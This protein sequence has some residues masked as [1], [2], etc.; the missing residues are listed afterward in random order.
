[1]M[2]SDHRPSPVTLLSASAA[3][4][5]LMIASPAWAQ[6]DPAAAVTPVSPADLAAEDT[7]ETIIVTA[8]KREQILLDVP[9]SVSVVAEGTLERQQAVSIVDY[10]ELVPGLSLTQD[11][12]G[13]T[14]IVLRGVNTGSVSSTVGVYMDETP[15]GS[16][17]S[18]ANGGVLA[19]DFDTFDVARIEVLR[20]PQGTLYG[21]NALGGV[22][23]FVTNEPNTNRLEA[24]AQATLESVDDGGLGGSAAGVINVPIGDRAAIRATGFY[25]HLEGFIDAVGRPN[26]DINDADSYGGRVS[27]LVEPTDDISVRLTAHAQNIRVD[28]SSSFDADPVTFDPLD[29]DPTTG[30]PVDGLT[31][32]Q[33]RPDNQDVDYRLYSG[34]VD[35]DLGFA[36][37]TS[38]TAYGVIDQT[39]QLD[40]TIGLGPTI[41]FLYGTFGGTTEDLGVFL[42]GDVKTKKFTQEVRLSSPDSDTFEW[43][44]GGYYTH[45]KA[46]IFQRFEP[47]ELASLNE[48]PRGLL[49]FDEFIVLTLD[50]KYKEFSGFGNITWHVSPQFEVSAGGR[51]SHNKQSAVQ[52]QEGA[53]LL[54]VGQD[55]PQLIT[56]ES[57]EN[58][59]TWSFSPLYK[60]TEDTSVYARAAKGYRPGGPNAVPPGAGP[61]FPF[62]FDADTLVS[63]EAGIKTQSS[64]RRF[65]LDAAVYYIDWKDVLIFASF[66]SDIGPV[67]ANDNG[68]K[69]TSYGAE[70]AATF[71]P[72]TGLT[73]MANVAYNKAELKDDTPPVTGGLDGDELPFSPRWSGTLSADYEWP[74]FGDSIA[75]V[76][77]DFRFVSEQAAGFDQGY[78]EEFGRRL[79]LPSYEV[80]DLRAGVDLGNFSLTAFVR[81][82]LNSGG[83]TNLG[84]FGTRPVLDPTEPGITA[85]SASPIR[86]RTFGVTLGAEF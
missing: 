25:R 38:A 35:W 68:G 83:L 30:D 46:G 28:D 84:G 21:A 22:L 57:S 70:A 40:Q 79:E 65:T 55:S 33:F 54:L 78:R 13:E 61:E 51:Y 14:R 44:I 15:F 77:G 4:L 27:F 11:N 66:D 80:V 86:P 36:T 9:Q 18:L 7:E 1:M 49:G 52:F 3:T 53:F 67:G 43:L 39:Q 17:S 2:G 62:Q 24:R 72:T 47:F 82:L 5:A 32:T 69:A 31:R 6:E 85:L 29:F 75:F 48:I 59:F 45:E 42:R 34:I 73:L 58:V 50:S 63:Y 56:G 64:D 81:N 10:A 20:G 74:V 23:R 60:V 37:L 26:E 19:G 8:Q 12:P 41:T 16:S 76:G 71:R